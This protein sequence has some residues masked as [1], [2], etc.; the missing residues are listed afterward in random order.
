[1][2]AYNTCC[3]FLVDNNVPLGLHEVHD[4]VYNMLRGQYPLLPAQSVIKIYKD[5][6]ASIRS[7]RSNY[8]KELK[9]NSN[10]VWATP[11]K[12]N[13]SMHLDKRLY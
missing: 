3:N 12:H 9:K 6:M 1:M 8:K 7:Q 11:Q 2:D 4:A 13:K 10:V 5:S